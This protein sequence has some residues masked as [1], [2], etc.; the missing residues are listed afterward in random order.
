MHDT[1]VLGR[2]LPEFEP[3]TCLVQ[4]EFYHQFTT[5]EHTLMCLEHLDRVWQATASPYSHYSEILHSVERPFVLYL[6]L[7]LH[8]AGKA[9][10]AG[11]HA[12]S[13][14][15]MAL[16]VA[17][18]LG[19]DGSTAHSLQL[20]IEN[21]LLMAQISQRRDLDDPAVIRTFAAQV[22]NPENLKLLTLHTF[23][24]SL[25]TSDKL[26]NGFKD[27]LLQR[28]Y[29]KTFHHL[30][31]DRRLQVAE[32]RQRGLLQEEVREAARTPT[33]APAW[34]PEELEAHFSS[35]PERYFHI[36]GVPEILADLDLVHR[37]LRRQFAADEDAFEPL[38][39]WHHEPSRGYSVVRICTWDRQGLF[40]KIT[41]ALTAAGLNILGAQIFT[42][43]DDI[44]LDTFTVAEARTGLVAPREEREK[45]E[46]LL[47]RSLTGVDV[48]FEEQIA[49]RPA[50][51]P[52]YQSLEGE[53]LPITL[54]FDNTISDTCTVLDLEMEDHVGLLYTVT[55]TLAEFK[56]DISLARVCTEQ[57]AAV[58]SFYLAE[59]AGGKITL[60]ERQEEIAARLRERL[61]R[62][63]GG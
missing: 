41:G 20:V 28:L 47:A 45:F 42:R 58:D 4:H 12:E 52:L 3:L 48:D 46:R 55:R 54:R 8:D 37:F 39:L 19:L 34:A 15:R 18:R 6:A 23:A 22:Q 33:P 21:H 57:G 30:L 5:D 60:P 17:D 43:A 53:R 51:P 61:E 56:L 16:A 11:D 40:S 25:G 62:L 9:D 31:G 24:D 27:A 13:G 14:G 29:A 1:G 36:H 63:V 32:E 2:F 10:R 49:R 26:W 44:I 50:V 35:L 7:L 38:V 59:V